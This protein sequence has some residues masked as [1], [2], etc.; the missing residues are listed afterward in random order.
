[1][2]Y[3]QFVPS[4][5]FQGIGVD[6]VNLSF[7]RQRMREKRQRTRR[8]GLSGW[9]IRPSGVIFSDHDLPNSFLSGP[10]RGI[11]SGRVDLFLFI[12]LREIFDIKDDYAKTS[13]EHQF[14]W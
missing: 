1:V 7:V 10:G 6:N 3:L 14:F 11:K 9:M 2:R 5:Y 12:F 8:E 4:V 13:Q